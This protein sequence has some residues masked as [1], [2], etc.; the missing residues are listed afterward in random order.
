MDA[1][2]VLCL[3]HSALLV[4]MMTPAYPQ[5]RGDQRCQFTAKIENF[6]NRLFQGRLLN[7]SLQVY[8]RR[9]IERR[10]K[11]NYM[12]RADSIV[13][14]HDHVDLRESLHTNLAE[15]PERTREVVVLRMIQGL[16]G[17]EV[18]E[19]LGCSAAEVSRLL[20]QGLEQLRRLL[21]ESFVK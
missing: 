6:K 21:A 5:S 4:T 12:A 19:L 1:G 11:N 9:G 13:G 10:A 8:R 14:T 2:S 3:N 17:N 15:L 18:K 20:H 16:G 7:E